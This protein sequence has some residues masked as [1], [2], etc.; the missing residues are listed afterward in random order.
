MSDLFRRPGNPQDLKRITADLQAG[1]PIQ[2]TEYNFYTLANIAKRYLL[3]VD[4][5]IF[6]PKNEAQ[7]LSVLDLPDD[8]TRIAALH[9]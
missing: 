1:R 6:G 3:H 2:W 8:E 5:G 7:M 4:G 9:K